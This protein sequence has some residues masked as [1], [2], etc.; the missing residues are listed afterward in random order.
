MRQGVPVLN[1]P[2]SNPRCRSDS[3]K[4]ELV[5]AIRPPG[6][7]FSP[8]WS[9]PRRNVPDVTT[10]ALPTTDMPMSVSTPVTLIPFEQI[11]ETVA[12]L[13]SKPDVRSRTA[14]IRN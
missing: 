11:F 12:C 3:L 2:T 5:S 10:T 8:T 4:P 14:F 6:R 1:R 7:E 9:K 13:I